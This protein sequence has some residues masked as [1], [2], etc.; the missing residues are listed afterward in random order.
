MHE[1][2]S[3]FYYIILYYYVIQMLLLLHVDTV[4]PWRRDGDREREVNL[5]VSFVVIKTFSCYCKNVSH[6]LMPSNMDVYKCM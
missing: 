5:D 4:G 3:H 1:Y 6:H 2:C